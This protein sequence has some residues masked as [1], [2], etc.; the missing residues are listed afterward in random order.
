MKALEL[1]LTSRF[2]E[3]DIQRVEPS[4]SYHHC[5]SHLPINNPTTLI[6]AISLRSKSDFVSQRI[7][8]KK[9]NKIAKR[10]LATSIVNKQN[11]YWKS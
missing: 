10:L 7:D 3:V 1:N 4:C 5:P 2:I 8:R 11:Y 6:I 9:Y